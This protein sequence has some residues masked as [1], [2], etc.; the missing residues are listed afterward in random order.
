MVDY[1][2][3]G[4]TRVR[5]SRWTWTGTR[6]GGRRRGGGDI[7]GGGSGVEHKE[8]IGSDEVDQ[9]DDDEVDWVVTT[10]AGWVV[11]RWIK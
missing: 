4:G 9:I 10:R 5:V 6:G 7:K 8:E 3:Q 1:I 2:L 11:T